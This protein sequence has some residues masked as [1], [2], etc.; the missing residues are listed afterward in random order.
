M[1]FVLL[2]SNTA[3]WEKPVTAPLSESPANPKEELIEPLD[4]KKIR[5]GSA[6]KQRFPFKEAE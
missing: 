1:L 2:L 4:C 5:R 6:G 3:A